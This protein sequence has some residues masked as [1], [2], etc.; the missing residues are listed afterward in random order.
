VLLEGGGTEDRCEQSIPKEQQVLV[1]G[2]DFHG[3]LGIG[4]EEAS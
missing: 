3:Q 4:S 1:W 2:S